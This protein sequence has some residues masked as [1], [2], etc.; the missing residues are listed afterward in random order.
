[1]RGH[2]CHMGRP[3]HL[4]GFLVVL[5]GLN[6]D[7]FLAVYHSMCRY[8]HPWFLDEVYD[9]QQ[10]S[11]PVGQADAAALKGVYMDAVAYLKARDRMCAG[12]TTCTGCVLCNEEESQCKDMTGQIEEAVKAVEQWVS[13]HKRKTRADRFLELFPTAKIMGDGS[14]DIMPCHIDGLYRDENNGCGR[15][16]LRCFECRRGFWLEEVDD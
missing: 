1:M 14:L 13:E 8:L 7:E 6:E 5:G 10:R 16:C 11:S 4:C 3:G 2:L 15:K 9:R 12:R